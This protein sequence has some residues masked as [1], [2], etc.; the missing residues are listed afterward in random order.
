MAKRRVVAKQ[1]NVPKPRIEKNK[2]KRAG[3][4]AKTKTSKHKGS[5]NYTKRKSRGQGK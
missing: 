2:K 4:H 3:V 1:A 5:K